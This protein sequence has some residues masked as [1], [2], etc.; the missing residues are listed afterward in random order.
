MNE[1]SDGH[2]S[3]IG[4]HMQRMGSVFTGTTMV[5]G[6]LYDPKEVFSKSSAELVAL[7]D[8]QEKARIKKV[9]EETKFD[10]KDMSR[11]ARVAIQL[12]Q[13]ALLLLAIT[14]IIVFAGV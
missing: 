7:F 12:L 11:R 3:A 1:L 9:L 10:A 4:F 6:E 5:G 14:A 13:Y 2:A 8:T